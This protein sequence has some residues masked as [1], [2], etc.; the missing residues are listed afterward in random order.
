MKMIHIVP[1]APTSARALSAAASNRSRV[2]SPSRNKCACSSG[3]PRT[4]VSHVNHVNHADAFSAAPR[5]SGNTKGLLTPAIT[6]A[7]CAP[8]FDERRDRERDEHAR[9]LMQM[10]VVERRQK[11]QR[12]PSAAPMKPSMPGNTKM[13]GTSSR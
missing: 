2:T 5:T 9:S 1:P 6:A 13:A 8:K 3:T 12:K 4:R 10:R 7:S 11:N